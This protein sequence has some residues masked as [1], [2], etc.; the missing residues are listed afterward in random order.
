MATKTWKLGEVARGGVI[1]AETTKKSIILIAKEWDFS[2]GS[3]RSSDQ[4][5][6]KELNRIEVSLTDSEAYRTCLEY[7]QDETT[8]YW[9]DEIMKWVGSKVELPKSLFW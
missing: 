2:K 7:L 6:A 1:T 3:R 4:S 9:A 5:N 8:S